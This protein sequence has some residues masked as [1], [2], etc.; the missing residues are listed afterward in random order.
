MCV[1]CATHIFLQKL[2]CRHQE[3]SLAETVTLG[4]SRLQQ[5]GSGICSEATADSD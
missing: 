5:V 4:T 2:D 1:A 3:Q